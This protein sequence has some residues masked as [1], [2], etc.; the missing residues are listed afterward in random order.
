[1]LVRIATKLLYFYQN[2]T[3]SWPSGALGTGATL[4]NG[5]CAVDLGPSSATAAGSALTLKLQVR[6]KSMFLGSQNVYLNASNAA[7]TSAGY[8]QKG[9]WTVSN[10]PQAVSVSPASGTGV[11][12]TFSFVA[13]DPMGYADIAQAI[14][15]IN[16]TTDGATG[17]WLSYDRASNRVSFYQNETGA[18]LTGLLGVSGILSNG[19]C[20]LDLGRSGSSGSSTLLTLAL[21]LQFTSQFSGSRNLYMYVSSVSG[22]ASEYQPLSTWIVP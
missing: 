4:E 7:G 12:Q 5:R 16:S 8:Q 3:G 11:A 15:L 14:I 10:V 20:S 13:S 19:R 22:T 9:T 6:F 1:M 2:E 21:Q 17:C 18:W